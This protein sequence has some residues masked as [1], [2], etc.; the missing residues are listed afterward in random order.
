MAD[1]TDLI[2]Y[3]TN[4]LIIQYNGEPKAQATIALFAKEMLMNG[5]MLDVLNG[6]DLD[7]AVG[8]Q[9]DVLG[10]YENIDRFYAAFDPVDYFSLETYTEVAPS[11][12]PRY[13]FTDYASYPTDPPAGC[14]IYSEIVAAKGVLTDAAFRT[15]IYLKIIQNYSN[16]GGGDIDSRI[17]ALF[18]DAIRMEDSGNMSMAYIIDNTLP[19]TLVEAILYKK[20]LPR[21]MAVFGVVISGVS[22][23]MFG[24][25]DYYGAASPYAYGFSDYAD[26]ASLSGIDLT[27]DL[28][29]VA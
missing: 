6:Y 1:V 27:Y 13:G 22:E 7:T 24:M 19:L 20:V 5:V 9:L 18:G 4:L 25:T 8:V 23:L 14:L 16:Y 2:N 10:K 29:S 21:P 12:P 3:Y 26:Y 11:T 15:L 28:I 17:Y